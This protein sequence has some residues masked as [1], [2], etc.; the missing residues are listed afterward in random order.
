MSVGNMDIKKRIGNTFSRLSQKVD[1]III[2]NYNEQSIDNN[3]FYGL[4]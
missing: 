2:K 1:A 3:F 4:Q